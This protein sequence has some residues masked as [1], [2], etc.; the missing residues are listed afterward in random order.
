MIIANEILEELKLRENVLMAK[1][2]LR[3]YKK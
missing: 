2:V 3:Y 1:S